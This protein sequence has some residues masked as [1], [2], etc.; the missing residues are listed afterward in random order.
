VC[1]YLVSISCNIS[2][3]GLCVSIYVSFMCKLFLLILCMWYRSNVRVFICFP[4]FSVFMMSIVSVIFPYVCPVF[5]MWFEYPELPLLLLI[6]CICSLYLVWNARPACP[7]YLSEQSRHFIWYM[8]LFICLC[9]GFYRVLY[10]ISCSECYFYFCI[11][12]KVSN[13][14]SLFST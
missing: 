4:F 13:F 1:I 7:M 6:A 9:G 12:K 3:I 2:N 5:N 14:P 10:C 8:P 11:S